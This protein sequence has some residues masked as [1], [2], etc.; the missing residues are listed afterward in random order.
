M[1]RRCDALDEREMAIR[2]RE[3]DLAAR[4]RDVSE[5]EARVATV[6]ARARHLARG[7]RE[8]EAALLRARVVDFAP[9]GQPTIGGIVDGS[10]LEIH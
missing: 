6:E 5:R 8:A 3:A 1:C 2:A 10:T 4:E 7:M 9:D